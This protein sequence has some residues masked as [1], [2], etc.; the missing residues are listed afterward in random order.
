MLNRKEEY[1]KMAKVESSHWWYRNLH[2]LV[3]GVL[4]KYNI[5]KSS[6]ILD[7]GCGT[8]GG[9]KFLKE[10]GYNRIKG[11]DLS[12]HAVRACKEYGLNVVKGNIKNI[13]TVFSG[14]K[15]DVVI[16]NDVLYF[17]EREDIKFFLKDCHKILEDKGIVI[18]NLPAIEAFS[19][20]HDISVGIGERFSM[21]DIDECFLVDGFSVEKKM[22][23]PFLL[24][25]LIFIVRFWQSIKLRVAPPSSTKSDIELPHSNVNNFLYK[26]IRWENNS[27]KFKPF[28][29]SVFLVLYKK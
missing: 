5:N 21:S 28:G 24:S 18:L 1:I 12:P 23:W 11:F 22:Y 27:L 7:A 15:F 2:E 29:S 4:V 20:E 17:L 10:N 9:I 19:G 16:S 6:N 13:S 3:V 26:L 25:P 14:E 8:G